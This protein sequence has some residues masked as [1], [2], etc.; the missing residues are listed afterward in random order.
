MT[1]VIFS[2]SLIARDSRILDLIQSAA[3]PSQVM[4]SHDSHPRIPKCLSEQFQAWYMLF[5]QGQS[6]LG[7][8][9]QLAIYL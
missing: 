1:I 6:C 5:R 3:D 2:V 8:L 7:P 9:A 4:P